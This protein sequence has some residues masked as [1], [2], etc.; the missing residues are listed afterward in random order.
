MQEADR[1][2]RELEATMDGDPWYGSAVGRI[3]DGVDASSAAAYPINGAHS[4]WELVLHMT[5]WVN[6]VR[7]R[8]DGGRHRDPAEGDWPAVTATTEDAW[9]QAAASLRQAHA[10]I[11]RTLAP[12]DDADLQCQVGG[13]QVDADGNRVTLYQTVIG[14]LQHDAYHAG[15][16][17]LLKK[18]LTRTGFNGVA[19]HGQRSGLR[20]DS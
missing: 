2:Q 14:I 19:N 11:R 15:Q 12:M 5:A 6:E 13:S 9:K 18:A 10:E 16:I 20:N 4:I 7:R 3:L 17:A 1:L 8:L